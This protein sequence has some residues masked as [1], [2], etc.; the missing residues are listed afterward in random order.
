MATKKKAVKKKAVKKKVVKKVVKKITRKKAAPGKF[1]H[2][3]Q[4]NSYGRFDYDG[5]RGISVNVVVEA[6]SPEDAN[7]R[8]KRIGLYFSG[9]GDCECCGNRWYEQYSRSNNE[10]E[11][12]EFPVV[13]GVKVKPGAPYPSKT[14]R[15][16]KWLGEGQFEGFIHYKNGKVSGFWK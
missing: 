13:Y 2:F 5:E 3:R 7:D 16:P 8:A 6:D 11:V 1:Y 15:W 4:N 10:E 9:R 14:D 12:T